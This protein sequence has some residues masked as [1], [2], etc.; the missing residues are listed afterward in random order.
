[1]ADQ[2]A[3]TTDPLADAIAWRRKNPE[4]WHAMV[5]WALEDKAAGV[6]P[7][8]DLYL[9][10]LRRPH[11]AS[12]LGL[13]RMGQDPVLANDHLTSSL[14]RLLNREYDVGCRTRAAKVDGWGAVA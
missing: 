6:R 12:L 1:M 9:H 2:L 8:T 7:S 3:L 4:C 13:K 10:I 5:R 14:A 11:F